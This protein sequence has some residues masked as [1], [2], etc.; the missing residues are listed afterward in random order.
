MTA[1]A[2]RLEYCIWGAPRVVLR[3]TVQAMILQF[4][5]PWNQLSSD[6]YHTIPAISLGD[7]CP[8]L[9]LLM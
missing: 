8:A 6:A 9:I 5:K 3:D 2:C 1:Q 7:Y 4:V